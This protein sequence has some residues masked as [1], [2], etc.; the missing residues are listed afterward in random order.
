[1]SPHVM[2]RFSLFVA[3]TGLMMQPAFGQ[4]GGGAG[5]TTTG[6]GAGA[7]ASTTTGSTTTA[8]TTTRPPTT[9]TPPPANNQTTPQQPIFVSGRVLLEDGTPP[10]ESVVIE[11]VCSGAP[12]SEGYTD[13]RGYFSIQLGARNNGVLHDASEDM[14]GFS[15]AASSGSMDT[16]GGSSLGQSSPM[17]GGIASENRFMDCDLR[18]RL[19][20]FRSQTISLANRRPMDPPDIGTILLHRLSPTEGTTVSAV[21]L[22][23]PKDA[24]K[25]YDKGMEALKKR[26][27]EDAVKNFERAVE[28]YPRY[29]T[30][31]YELG[32]LTAARDAAMAHG[33]YLE[34]VK[35]DPKFVSPYMELAVLEW[36]GEKWQQVADLTEK[37]VKLDSFDYPQA[38]FL[39]AISNYFLKNYEAAEKSALEAE[40]LDTRRQYPSTIRL[41]GVL[42]AQ[43]EDYTGA[44]EKF[45]QYLKIAPGASDAPTVRKQLDQLEKLA[46]AKQ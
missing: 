21:S 18:A 28:V 5:A 35:A 2:V 16:L 12:H 15:S 45:K 10:T 22:A 29:A 1:M 24:K 43:K 46:A 25:A 32:L 41:L 37:V 27:P 34:A 13:S 39:N 4:R 8:P 20:G 6:G 40:R 31:W 42:L 33:Y 38:H 9:T 11:R 17:R 7:G 23:A 3:A 19:V 26:K 36:K 44:T 30:A 14:T